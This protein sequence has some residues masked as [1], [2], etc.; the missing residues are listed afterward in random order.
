M[1]VS[2]TAGHRHECG[3]SQVGQFRPHPSQTSISRWVGG[4]ET[5]PN[6]DPQIC[7]GPVWRA[8]LLLQSLIPLSPGTPTP[9]PPRRLRPQGSPSRRPQAPQVCAPRGPAPERRLP[10]VAGRYPR[11][12]SGAGISHPAAGVLAV[13]AAGGR[14]CSG[15]GA[16]GGSCGARVAPAV[17]APGRG[18]CRPLL[19]SRAAAG[20]SAARPA[21][22]A[23]LPA[24]PAPLRPLR[25]PSLSPLPGSQAR[26]PGLG[27]EC[28]APAPRARRA[29]ESGV[30]ARGSPGARPCA[31]QGTWA[32]RTARVRGLGEPYRKPPGR[33]RAPAPGERRSSFWPAA[34][35]QDQ[36]G[37]PARPRLSCFS[38]STLGTKPTVLVPTQI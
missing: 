20:A 32:R 15:G 3:G 38:A 12:R 16:R 31:G 14:D 26:P 10:V 18:S 6:K 28:A 11:L 24:R 21:P 33:A 27:G 37:T 29:R 35:A 23:S 4:Y 25:P 1:G 19:G 5:L 30:A 36:A 34:G 9:G 2:L 17:A 22:S 8:A 13:W 7:K